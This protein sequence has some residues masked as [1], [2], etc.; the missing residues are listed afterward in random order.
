MKRLAFRSYFLSSYKLLLIQAMP[1][2]KPLNAKCFIHD[3]V[4]STLLFSMQY[5]L[6]QREYD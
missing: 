5:N 1:L 4:P 6:N 2:D 3:V